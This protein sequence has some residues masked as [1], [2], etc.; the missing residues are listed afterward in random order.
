M[1]TMDYIKFGEILKD[2][3]KVTRW[4]SEEIEK[5]V[6]DYID[7]MIGKVTIELSKKKKTGKR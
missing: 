1:S 3:L 7:I 6:K 2:N 5:K 4:G